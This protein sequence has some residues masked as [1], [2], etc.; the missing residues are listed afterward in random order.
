MHMYHFQVETIEAVRGKL[1]RDERRD[2]T[3]Y[4]LNTVVEAEDPMK[5]Y[6]LLARRSAGRLSKD[7]S[8]DRGI[9]ILPDY[10]NCQVVVRAYAED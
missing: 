6:R 1:P 10:G 8:P 5:A 9:L 2:V 7:S 3:Q 4:F